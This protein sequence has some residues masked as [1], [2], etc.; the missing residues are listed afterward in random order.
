MTDQLTQQQREALRLI[1]WMEFNAEQQKD[2]V[3]RDS[4]R[5]VRTY[6]RNSTS[7][8]EKITRYPGGYIPPEHGEA[9]AYYVEGWNDCVGEMLAAA[10][11]PE[12]GQDA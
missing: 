5:Y 11:T 8:P 1:E 3:A 6:I 10:P 12:D 9:G 2:W 7:V 4:A